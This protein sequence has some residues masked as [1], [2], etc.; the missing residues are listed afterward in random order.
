MALYGISDFIT[1]LREYNIK[2]CIYGHLHNGIQKNAIQGNFQGIDFN[3]V[4]ADFLD[5]IPYNIVF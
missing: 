3:L 4:A 2:K 5:F 1:L